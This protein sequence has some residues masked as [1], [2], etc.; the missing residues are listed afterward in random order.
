MDYVRIRYL[1]HSWNKIS[2]VLF[3]FIHRMFSVFPVWHSSDYILPYSINNFSQSVENACISS[4]DHL[5]NFLH[6]LQ[7][8]I[9]FFF[10]R[11]EEFNEAKVCCLRIFNHCPCFTCLTWLF[12]IQSL[13]SSSL[14]I[15]PSMST[16][17]VNL[18]LNL[19]D[20]IGSYLGKVRIALW[21][22][23]YDC[24]PSAFTY[25][26]SGKITDCT[27]MLSV[28]TFWISC[29]SLSYTGLALRNGMQQ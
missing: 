6:C 28:L 19:D 8:E 22:E 13:A 15:N 17:V 23:S 29:I 26:F 7:Q 24:R 21:Y 16:T 5:S 3:F 2:F 25:D 11:R 27:W 20:S 4:V 10:V 9:K 18:T 1:N 12:F 14:E